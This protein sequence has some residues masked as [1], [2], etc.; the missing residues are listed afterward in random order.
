MLPAELWKASKWIT[1]A[2]VCSGFGLSAIIKVGLETIAG[3]VFGDLS[4]VGGATGTRSMPQIG[5][6]PG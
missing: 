3:V 1:V 5:H 4:E 6:A 2:I